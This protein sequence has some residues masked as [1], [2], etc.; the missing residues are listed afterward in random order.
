MQFAHLPD[1]ALLDLLKQ[2][3]ARAFQAIYQRHWQTLYGF[4][5]L[6]LGN[7]EDAEEIIHEI[8]VKLWQ[9]RQHSK[10]QNLGIYLFIAARNQCNKLIKSQINFRKFR[11]YQILHEVLAS[12]DT[13]NLIQHQDLVRAIEE[14]MKKMPEKTAHIFKMSKIEELPIKTIAEQLSLSEKAVEYHITKSLKILRQHLQDFSS[15]N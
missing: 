2:D 11:E 8:M 13:E 14:T 9:N 4:V 12:Y 5:Y 15:N 10:I 7:H 3:D 1:S 6:Q